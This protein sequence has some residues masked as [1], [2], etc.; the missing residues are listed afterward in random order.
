MKN[1]R[2]RKMTKAEIKKSEN[3]W[4]RHCNQ[5][6]RFGCVPKLFV[7]LPAYLQT[8]RMKRFYKFLQKWM[9]K[10]ANDEQRRE[11]D[12]RK[13]NYKEQKERNQFQS[14]KSVS[15]ETSVLQLMDDA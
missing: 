9:E 6:V 15:L 2:I 14:T 11:L 12:R 4:I 13:K 5:F 10:N 1:S 8:E 3:I 7:E